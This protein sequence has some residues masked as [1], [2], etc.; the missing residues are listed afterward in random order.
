MGTLR[1][2]KAVAKR[3]VSIWRRRPIYLLGSLV[4]MLFC[5]VF[6]LTFLGSGLPSDLPIGIVDRDGSSISRNFIRQLDGTQL[7]KVVMFDD[8]EQARDQ[9][10]KGRITSFVVIPSGMSAD[11]QANRQPKMTFYIN[12][13]YFV[14]GALAYQDIL[15]MLN[16]TSGAVQK[17][18]L[19][20]K[21]LSEHEIEGLIRPINIDTHK[22]GNPLSSYSECLSPVMLPGFLE[23]VIILIIIYSLG[24]ELK[25]GTSRHLLEVSGDNI[26]TA[27]LGKIGLYTIY[28]TILGFGLELIM[29]HWMHFSIAGSVWNMLLAIL[30]L[31]LAS[32]SVAVLIIGLLPVC[33]FALS[34]GALFSVLAFSM[35]GFT[36]PVEAMPVWLRGFSLMFPLRHFYLMEVQEVFYGSGFAGWWQ[37]ALQLLAFNLLPF[38]VLPRLKRAYIYQDYPKN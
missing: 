17:E 20:A 18:V 5:T 8:L 22:I 9:M 26:G 15:T 13:L 1:H 36:L 37:E 35:T 30:L 14:G 24:A 27:I 25:Y 4:P 34:V 28:F 31:V 7:G 10:Q 2:L 21:G 33:R 16:L 11:I 38:L 29:Y 23:M 3:E 19:T 12:G 32:E 6:F